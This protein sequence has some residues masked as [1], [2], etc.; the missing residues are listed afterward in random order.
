MR[1]TDPEALA[2]GKQLLDDGMPYAIVAETVG[3]SRHTLVKHLPG[4]KNSKD[5][6]SVWASILTS[7]KLRRLHFEIQEFTR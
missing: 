2:L 3:I 1:S 7:P 5:W 4:Y 6:D